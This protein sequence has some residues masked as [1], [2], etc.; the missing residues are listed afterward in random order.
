MPEIIIYE[1]TAENSFSYN[2]EK[3]QLVIYLTDSAAESKYLPKITANLSER[4]LA[5]QGG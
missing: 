3:N 5:V 1:N 4:G 2:F